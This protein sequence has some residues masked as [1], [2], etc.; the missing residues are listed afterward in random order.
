[1][2]FARSTGLLTGATTVAVWANGKGLLHGVHVI[3]NTTGASDVLIYD[4]TDTVGATA[5]FSGDAPANRTQK[6]WFDPPIRCQTG[7]YAS[8]PAGSQAIVYTG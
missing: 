4:A 5:I 7:M 1:M 6:Y 8:I 3:S 2:H